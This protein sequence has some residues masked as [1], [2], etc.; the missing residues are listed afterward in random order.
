MTAAESDT[1]AVQPEPDT[2]AVAE[3]DTAAPRPRYDVITIGRVGVDLYPLQ[4][5]VGLQD[6]TAFSK[7]LGG[8]PTNVAIAAARH[9]LRT[10]VITRTGADPF[11]RFVHESLRG[12]GVDDAFVSAVEELPT[13]VTFCEIFPPDSFPIYFYRWP[14]AP[15]LEIAAE[16]LD[17]AAIGSA[18]VFWAT[19]TGLS[20]E[21]SRSAHFAAWTARGRAPLTVLDLDYRAQFWADQA[22]AR[23][24]A[25]RALA[26]CTVAVGNS[27][28]CEVAVGVREPHRAAEA[29]LEL[30]VQLAVVKLGPDGVLA[31]TATESVTVPPFPVQVCNGLGAGDAFGGALC[32]GLLRQWPLERTIRFAGAA[33]AIVAGRLECSTAMPSTSEVEALTGEAAH[34]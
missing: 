23:Q 7:S 32:H 3:P 1:T 11:G 21:P 27:E 30:G 9:G 12:F 22:S 24:Q 19:L 16:Q 33:G 28:E 13:P 6:V 2:A 14:K 26:H 20:A 4:S 17:L 25:R 34:V 29:L 8:S 5:G 15:D 10:A 18:R 31:R